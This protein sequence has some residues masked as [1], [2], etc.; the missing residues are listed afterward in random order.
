MAPARIEEPPVAWN[1][2]LSRFDAKPYDGPPRNI[3]WVDELKFDSALQPKHY[4][5]AGTHPDSRILFTGVKILESTGK[6]PYEG[7]VLIEGEHPA[8]LYT[9]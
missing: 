2:P 5:M 4:E 3:P 8:F 9:P 1:S 7:D 6:L